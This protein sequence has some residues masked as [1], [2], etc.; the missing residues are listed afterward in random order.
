MNSLDE[1]TFSFAQFPELVWLIAGLVFLVGLLAGSYPALVLSAFNPIEV[2]KS[3]LRLGGSNFFTKSL[4]TRSICIV[5]RTYHFNCDHSAT[6]ELHAHLKI[7]VST[8][9]IL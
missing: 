2:L 7:P 8:K 5:C 1:L 9:R 4:V 3:K 6:S